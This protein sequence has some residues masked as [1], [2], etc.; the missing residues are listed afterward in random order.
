MASPRSERRAKWIARLRPQADVPLSSLHALASAV[1]EWKI[2][3]R[4]AT[5]TAN[6]VDDVLKL[7]HEVIDLR[8]SLDKSLR[9]MSEGLVAKLDGR[10]ARLEAALK[11]SRAQASARDLLETPRGEFSPEAASGEGGRC[12]CCASQGERLLLLLLLSLLLML[13]L[14]GAPGVAGSRRQTG[15]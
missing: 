13:G 10:L 11:T 8:E 4:Q 9:A 12:R 3:L 6:D 14:V 1:H 5:C 15:R 7:T 2:L